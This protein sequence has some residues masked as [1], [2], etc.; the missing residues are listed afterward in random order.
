MPGLPFVNHKVQTEIPSALVAVGLT[1]KQRMH[2][3]LTFT[4]AYIENCKLSI[5]FQYK[6][7]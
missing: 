6:L 3:V 4:C 5:K 2:E 7:L 1:F